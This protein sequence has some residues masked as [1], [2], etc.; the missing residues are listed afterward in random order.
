[1]I[2]VLLAKL[3]GINTYIDIQLADMALV[4]LILDLILAALMVLGAV[5]LRNRFERLM[6]LK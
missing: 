3:I 1:M 5:R 4:F 6:Q 2:I